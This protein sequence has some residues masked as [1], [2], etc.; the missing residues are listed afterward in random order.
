[1]IGVGY[2]LFYL[3]LCL[4]STNTVLVFVYALPTI[5]LTGMFNDLKLSISS[6]VGVSVIAI[7]HAIKYASFRNWEGGAVADLEIEILIMIVCSTFSFVVNRVI[8]QANE[9]K[10]KEI[11]EAG[12]KSSQ[13]LDSIMLISNEMADEVSAVSEKMTRLANSSDE[14]YSAMQEVTSGTN[15]TAESIQNQLYKT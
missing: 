1:M 3:V 12:E 11:N 15:E 6:S 8:A 4:I 14:I 2:G 10:V 7:I 13:M 9:M 5:L